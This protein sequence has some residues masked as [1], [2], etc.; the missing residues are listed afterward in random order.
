MLLPVMQLF[1]LTLSCMHSLPVI[2]I[3]MKIFVVKLC[4]LYC[5]V[6]WCIWSVDYLFY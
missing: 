4:H 6:V 2:I 5:D 1:A 3:I